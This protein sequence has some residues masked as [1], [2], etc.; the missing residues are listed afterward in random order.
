M[1]SQLLDHT[2]TLEDKSLVVIDVSGWDYA[3]IQAVTPSGT[4]SLKASNDGGANSDVSTA[5]N[6][7]GVLA[8]KL[9]DNTSVST[10]AAAGLYRL[11]ISAKYL[12][13]GGESADADSLLI[14]LQKVS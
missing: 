8:T 12:S 9:V 4:I 3:T 10:I 14:H 5:A 13:I 2:H 7:T 6:F 11:V 1:I